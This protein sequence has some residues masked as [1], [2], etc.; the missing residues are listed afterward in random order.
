LT[1][2]EA[3]TTSVN[4]TVRTQSGAVRAP[5]S[6]VIPAGQRSVT[7]NIGGAAEG[8]ESSDPAYESV[9]SRVQVLPTSK[10]KLTVLSDASPVRVKV[11]DDNELPYPGVVVQ[12]RAT[13]GG[14]VDRLSGI[15]DA[16]GVVEFAW[17]LPADSASQLLAS[18]ESGPSVAIS[19]AARPTF[20]SANVLN[21]ASFVAGVV[22][23]GIASVFG[24]NLG[25][26]NARVFVNGRSTTVLFAND[27]QVN[28]LVPAD[29][30]TGTAQL[31]IQ[32]GTV[33]SAVVPVPVLNLQPG[34]FFDSA[35]GFGAVTVAGTGQLTAVQ[36]AKPGQFVEVYA[37]ALGSVRTGIGGLFET[38]VRPEVTIAGLPAQVVFSGLAPGYPGLYQ[39]NVR[40]P[41][42]VP[43]GSQPL[44]VTS[45]AVRSNEVRVRIE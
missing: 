10:L 8:T 36:P 41:D 25:G 32:A 20:L 26:T 14:S 2:Q 15:A 44:V 19:A 22:P 12:A 11:T 3:P 21:A 24:S 7:F 28:F 4:F 17:T 45:G 13:G 39:L 23:G 31:A 33:A 40:V 43:N 38:L 5:Q 42:S 34:L 37:T 16:N 1:L 27:G 6:V 18:I 30:P 35:S 9:A 29:V